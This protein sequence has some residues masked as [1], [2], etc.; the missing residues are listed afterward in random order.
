V[1]LKG[2]AS[3][4]N[5]YLGMNKQIKRK[6]RKKLKYHKTFIDDAIATDVM[7]SISDVDKM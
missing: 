6:R 3:S 7:T 1:S 4:T 5:E 2:N